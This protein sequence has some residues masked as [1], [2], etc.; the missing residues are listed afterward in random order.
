MQLQKVGLDFLTVGAVRGLGSLGVRGLVCLTYLRELTIS[1][2]IPA[3]LLATA[4]V[5]QFTVR[6]AT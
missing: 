1:S 6:S 2:V 4:S 5:C 3:L